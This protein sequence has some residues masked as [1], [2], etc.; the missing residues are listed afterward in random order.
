MRSI[1]S[2]RSV[3]RSVSTLMS[4]LV[5]GIRS[6]VASTMTPVSPMPP[7][8]AQKRSGSVSGLSVTRSPR[9][10]TTVM[11]ETCDPKVPSTWWF[12]PCTSA[13]MAPPTVTIRVPGVT[14]TKKPAGTSAFMSA[15]RLTPPPAVTV[16]AAVSRSI[17]AIVDR[18]RTVAPP[19]CA[20]S[21]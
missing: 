8:V 3:A 6:K 9:P 7:T 21:P 4:E 5:I 10:S 16:P 2:S 11:R 12:L 15:S 1:T 13:A 18:S 20:A 14:G 17:E 19:D